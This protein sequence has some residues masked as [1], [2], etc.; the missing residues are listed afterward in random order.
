MIDSMGLVSY[1]VRRN[2]NSTAVWGG[3]SAVRNG[4]GHFRTEPM[5]S[6]ILTI[7]ISTVVRCELN[8]DQSLHDACIDAS[9]ATK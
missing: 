1:N 7:Y 3:E 9:S 2:A 8:G 6:P 4:R 5:E